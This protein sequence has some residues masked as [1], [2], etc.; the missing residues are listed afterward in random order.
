VIV[1]PPSPT[2]DP[3]WR[4][5]NSSRNV[6]RGNAV[7]RGRATLASGNGN[8]FRSNVWFGSPGD[9]LLVEAVATGTRLVDNLAIQNADDGFDV[10]APGTLLKG[11]TAD[12]NGD[13]G[14]EAVPGVVDGGANHATG[15]GN[16]AQCL[17]VDC[18]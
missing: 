9:G 15:N 5:E 7:F 6:F 16:A 2:V 3:V 17:N 18:S 10:E 1:G 14:I 8:V 12:K 13:L 4:I 11:N